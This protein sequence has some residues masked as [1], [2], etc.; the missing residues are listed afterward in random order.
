MKLKNK[1]TGERVNAKKVDL[2][3]DAVYLEISKD[4]K[5][6]IRVY[7]SLAE[8]SAEWE[9]VPEKSKDFWFVDADGGIRETN[10][11]SNNDKSSLRN[12]GNYFATKEAAEKAVEKLKAWERLKNKGFRFV[13]FYGSSKCIDFDY[14]DYSNTEWVKENRSDLDLLFGGKD[15]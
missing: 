15:E 4:G 6:E 14:D 9:D 10:Y 11:L 5:Y 8:L 12:F 2:Y 13:G 3:T 7:N 1:K